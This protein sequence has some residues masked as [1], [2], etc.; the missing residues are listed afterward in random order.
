MATD[1]TKNLVQIILLNGGLLILVVTALLP[2]LNIYW[3]GTRWVFAFGAIMVLAERLTERY[4]GDNLRI[5][6]LYWLGKLSALLFCVAAGLL[7]LPDSPFQ[8]TLA[9]LT[10]GAV[11]QLY[12]SFVYDHE[13]KKEQNEA[14]NDK[15][16]N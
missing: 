9:F 2:L 14:N 15:K 5:K 11:M 3:A 4:D 12:V 10:A 1:K 13:M 7:F 16:K 8:N 6:R